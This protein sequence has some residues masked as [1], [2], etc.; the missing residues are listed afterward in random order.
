[1]QTNRY[2]RRREKRIYEEP[3]AHRRFGQRPKI[4]N[5]HI[6]MNL[7]VIQK[8]LLVGGFFGFHLG[9]PAGNYRVRENLVY[10]D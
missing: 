1:M 4:S 10:V 8:S 9:D 3:V 5:H 7:A 6:P 2:V